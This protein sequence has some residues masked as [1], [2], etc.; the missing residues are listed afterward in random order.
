MF[1]LASEVAEWDTVAAEAQERSDAW[2]ASVPPGVA[3]VERAIELFSQLLEVERPGDAARSSTELLVLDEA[4]LGQQLHLVAASGAASAVPDVA[5]VARL[6]AGQMLESLQRFGPADSKWVFLDRCQRVR[7]H[8]L[9]SLTALGRVIRERSGGPTVYQWFVDELGR[10]LVCRR[11]LAAL[12]ARVEKTREFDVGRR[13]RLAGTAIAILQ[14]HN[15]YYE[16]RL[17]D[18]ITLREL[19]GRVLAWVKS[20]RESPRAG[21]ALLQ[22]LEGFV[23]L[24]RQINRRSELI[25]HDRFLVPRLLAEIDGIA[26]GDTVGWRMFL[27]KTRQLWGASP[28]ID[29]E[30]SLGTGAD[31]HAVRKALT[32]LLPALS[33]AKTRTKTGGTVELL[34]VI[35]GINH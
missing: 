27:T 34:R 10:S 17:S 28:Q 19:Q 7:R 32:Q 18:R 33:G 23:S 4:S 16:L 3:F 25:E 20:L 14:G 13:L 30:L 8:L 35:E 11:I 24:T 22:D 26:V 15:A 31:R 29:R 6:E 12:W 2:A 9:R 1:S 5:F 21:A